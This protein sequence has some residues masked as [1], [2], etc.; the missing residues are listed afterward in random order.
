MFHTC[1]YTHIT[2]Y[3]I[4]RCLLE[5]GHPPRPRSMVVR[6]DL[7]FCQKLCLC[8]HK[9]THTDTYTSTTT[10]IHGGENRSMFLSKLC[11][12]IINIHTPLGKWTSATTAI[13]GGEDC[14]YFFCRKYVYSCIYI[15]TDRDTYTHVCTIGEYL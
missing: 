3:F 9:H 6:I 7:C 15:H 4:L 12:C 13:H 14:I 2:F 1:I 11:L 8:M 10:A 5:N